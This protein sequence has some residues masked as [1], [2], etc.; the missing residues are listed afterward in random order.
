MKIYHI[1]TRRAVWA[2]L[3]TLA[4]CGKPANPPENTPTASAEAKVEKI[5]SKPYPFDTDIVSG[6]P[7][8]AA[9]IT[10]VQDGH[11]VKVAS[12]E[13]AA[14]W[15]QN[16]AGYLAKI[17][18]AYAEAKPY[19]LDTCLVCGMKLE[20]DDITFVYLGRQ[21]KVCGGDEDCYA[22]FKKDPA[23]YLKMLEASGSGG[24]K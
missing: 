2:L 3:L 19:P 23:K 8:P 11:E 6:A 24:A 20:A 14:A 17:D 5:D 21:I 16:P 10:F 9:P 22:V 1:L 4:S 13:S 15:K 12:A 7:L 18:K